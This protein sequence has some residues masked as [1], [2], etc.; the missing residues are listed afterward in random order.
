LQ[1]PLELSDPAE[2]FTKIITERIET[3]RLHPELVQGGVTEDDFA[4]YLRLLG[5]D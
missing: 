1:F 4:M 2:M 3:W 5:I